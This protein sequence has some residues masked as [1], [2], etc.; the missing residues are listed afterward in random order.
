M[1]RFIFL[2]LGLLMAITCFSRGN[3]FLDIPYRVS[4]N[5]FLDKM[6]EHGYVYSPENSTEGTTYAFKGYFLDEKV[7]VIIECDPNEDLVYSV[8]VDFFTYGVP[9]GGDKAS[10]DRLYS[11]YEALKKWVQYTNDDYMALSEESS[12]EGVEKAFIL[13]QF[14]EGWSR[15]VWISIQDDGKKTLFLTFHDNRA[16]NHFLWGDELH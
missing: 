2:L 1:K 16:I 4:V 3:M 8:M 14:I 5:T 12:R 15:I 10:L 6:I 11:K 7:W 9:A 13:E